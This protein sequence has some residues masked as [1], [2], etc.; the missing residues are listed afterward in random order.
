MKLCL[1]PHVAN[2]DRVGHR[3]PRATDFQGA[4]NEKNTPLNI[5]ILQCL[6]ISQYTVHCG[7]VIRTINSRVNLLI[8]T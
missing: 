5:T 1:S 7:P 2:G 3:W 6:I 8:Q 4:L